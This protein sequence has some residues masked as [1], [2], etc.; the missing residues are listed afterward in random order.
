MQEIHAGGERK[1]PSAFQTGIVTSVRE[2]TADTAGSAPSVE[3]GKRKAGGLRHR[4][5][6]R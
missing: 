5:Y 4:P 1:L 2:A 6:S 3:T